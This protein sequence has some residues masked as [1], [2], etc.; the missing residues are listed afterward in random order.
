MEPDCNFYRIISAEEFLR[1]VK[2]HIYKRYK[3]KVNKEAKQI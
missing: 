1:R 3:N 2:K